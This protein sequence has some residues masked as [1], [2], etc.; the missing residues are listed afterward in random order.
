MGTRKP[1]L[2]FQ[3]SERIKSELIIAS[4]LLAKLVTL[5]G[6]ELIGAEKL[7][8]TFMEALRGE[9]RIAQNIEK[10]VNFL[11]AEKKVTEA[12]GRLR[13]SYHSEAARSISEALSFITTSSQ[14]AMEVLEEKGLI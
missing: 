7:L 5:R 1:I 13:L 11:G 9:I 8:I 14:G 2:I 3:Y 10:T 4:E 6:D 12:I